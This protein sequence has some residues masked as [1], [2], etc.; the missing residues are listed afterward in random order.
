MSN[1]IQIIRFNSVESTNSTAHQMVATERPES[2]AVVWALEQSKGRG[3]RNNSWVVEPSKNLTFSI[4]VYPSYMPI[5]R[6]FSLSEV[7]AT[8]VAS[9]ISELVAD[10]PVTIK[11]PNDIYIGNKKV[12]GLLLEHSIMGSSI[13]YSVVGI[14]IN[15]NQ[16]EFPQ[17]LPNPTSLAVETNAEYDLEEL[18][19]GFI[20]SFFSQLELLKSGLYDEIHEKFKYKLFRNQGFHQFENEAGQFTAKIADVR[21]SGEMVLE[22][23]DGRQVAYAFKEVS[24]VI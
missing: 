19:E 22:M 16:V 10:A 20:Q 24:Y 13:D 6:Q 7:A 8:S 2:E 17:S 15:V 14:G 1:E 9:V 4:I 12:G 11:W 21:Q 3:Q 23:A 5:N 18:L